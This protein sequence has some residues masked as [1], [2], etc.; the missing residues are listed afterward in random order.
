MLFRSAIDLLLAELTLDKDDYLIDLG[1]G[2]DQSE[3]GRIL[4]NQ[5]KMTR[6]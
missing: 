5:N 2:I 6:Y 3:Y 1:F 4:T